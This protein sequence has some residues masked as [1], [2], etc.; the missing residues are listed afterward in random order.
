MTDPSSNLPTIRAKIQRLVAG[1][2]R[3]FVEREVHARL[4]LLAVVARQHVLLLGPPGTAKSALAR[5]V[6]RAFRDAT[7]FEYLL[8]R[9]SHPDELFGPV[10]I[11]G[12]KTEDYR[13]V[14]DGF[15][16]RAEV[17]FV[18]EIFKANS[19]IL[20][21]LLSLINERVFHHGRH[22]DPS[23]LLGLIG[24]SNEAP[25][26]EGGLA[27]L[28][29][30]FLVRLAVPAVEEDEAFVRVCLGEL[31]AF[32]PDPAD[33]LTLAD[34]EAVRTAARAVAV[35]E[36]VREQLVG[37]RDDLRSAGIAASDRRWRW[38]VDL[39]RIAA[40]TSGRDAVGPIDLVLLQHCFG[41]PVETGVALKPII[42]R[43]LEALVQPASSQT[44][45]DT[46]D[47]FEEHEEDSDFAV[48]VAGRLAQLDAFEGHIGAAARALDA[49]R[50]A[51][52][53]EVAGCPW[54]TGIPPRLMAGLI[55]ARRHLARYAR[56][57][58]RYRE[59]LAAIDL[60]GEI[61]PQIRR[62]QLSSVG[63]A[64]RALYDGREPPLWLARA[65][66]R[67][68]DWIPVSP[69]GLLLTDQ[70]AA[71]AGAIQRALIERTVAAGQPV[72]EATRWHL[73][74]TRLELDNPLLF[75]LLRAE[76]LPLE[77]LPPPVRA[78]G[79]RAALE[80]LVEWLQGADVR[81][82]PAPPPLES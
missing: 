38:A 25:D 62:A 49:Q 54:V 56:A 76:G 65:G 13:R 20:N 5:A 74:V 58:E 52:E 24:A 63:H 17:A 28:Y 66:D 40:V 34:L 12:L 61:M 21:S 60:Y 45:A 50:D 32:D 46:W 18:D 19:A 15:L 27:A 36:R 47:G 42:R 4:A 1:L 29:D 79:P 72:T 35:P 48:A 2:D 59:R 75:R 43:A 69:D 33:Q 78:A 3:A 51:I 22:R 77:H 64:G 6:R 37:I 44:V 82:L 8:T 7:Y 80:R 10:S 70:R 31:E 26:P 67:P 39:L 55:G 73:T 16:P 23:P 41:D 68:D 11:P 53:A 57:L 71:I 14:T 9:F 30:R 81:R